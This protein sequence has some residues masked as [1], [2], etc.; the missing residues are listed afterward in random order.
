MKT[1]EIFSKLDKTLLNSLKK[2]IQDKEE[3][4]FR[5][6]LKRNTVKRLNWYKQD[7]NSTNRK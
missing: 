6:R 2:D 3:Q 1:P 4:D 5:K 7:E